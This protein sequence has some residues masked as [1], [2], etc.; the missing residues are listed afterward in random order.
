MLFF[1]KYISIGSGGEGPRFYQKI[2]VGNGT[3]FQERW[4][5]IFKG[6]GVR[7]KG[8]SKLKITGDI[9]TVTETKLMLF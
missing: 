3:N 9:A 8:C 6:G 4:G 7:L 2:H 1:S 5:K